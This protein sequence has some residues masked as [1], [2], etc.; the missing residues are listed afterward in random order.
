[1]MNGS[2]KD[3]NCAT[4]ELSHAIVFKIRYPDISGRIDG[5]AVATR[6][7]AAGEARAGQHTDRQRYMNLTTG[8]EPQLGGVID[9]HVHGHRGEVHE[10][11]LGDRPV[12]GDR[13]ANRGTDDRLF[14]DRG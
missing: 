6:N 5:D 10:H 14:G 4:N 8:H 2:V 13:S 7:A 12:A 9:D 3:R 11:D 1:M